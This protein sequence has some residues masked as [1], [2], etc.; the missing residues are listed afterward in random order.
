MKELI[1]VTPR[2]INNESIQTVS[3]RDLHVELHVKQDFSDWIKVQIGRADLVADVDYITL[4]KKRGPELRGLQGK[5]EYF[6]T[7]DAGKNIAM[8]SNSKKG[9]EVRAYFISCEKQLKSAL[10][11]LPDF[12]NPAI[13]A[14]AWADEVDAKRIALIKIA[15]DKPKVDFVDSITNAVG[16]ISVSELAKIIGT[17]RNRMYALLREH[18]YLLSSHNEPKQASIK[19]GWLR[20][21]E[22]GT[23]TDWAGIEHP[24]FKV[25]VTGKGQVYFEKKFREKHL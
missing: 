5:V 21:V 7:L 2:I 23:F 8:M 15:C 24:N 16:C 4:L 9:K 6:V 20:Y 17:G 22:I 14:R 25:V 3:A 13:A 10:I 18:G 19:S 11:T 12:T 1:A